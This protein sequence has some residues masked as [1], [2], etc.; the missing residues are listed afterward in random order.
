MGREMAWVEGKLI[1]AKV[2]WT[3]DLIKTPGQPDFSD[4]DRDLVHYGFFVK[5]EL[6]VRFVLVKR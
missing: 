6:R 1:M 2:L 5:P 4:V 3:F